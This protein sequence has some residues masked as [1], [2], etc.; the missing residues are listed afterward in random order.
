MFAESG[1]KKN[2]AQQNYWGLGG[3]LDHDL[4]N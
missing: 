3:A 4:F 2:H 1:G